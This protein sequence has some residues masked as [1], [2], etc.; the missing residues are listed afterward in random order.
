MTETDPEVSQGICASIEKRW[1]ASDQDVFI[2][3]TFWNPYVHAD[4]F[5][6]S[7]EFLPAGMFSLVLQVWCHVFKQAPDC[8]P[9]LGLRQATL[10]YYNC[11]EE[12]LDLSM[13]LKLAEAEAHEKVQL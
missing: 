10:D 1:A 11:Q 7:M 4:A 2:L 13:H 5:K 9:P 3:C 12:Y 6:R 8:E